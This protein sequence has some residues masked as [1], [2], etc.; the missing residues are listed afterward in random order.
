MIILLLILL[1]IIVL[2]LITLYFTRLVVYPKVLSHAY[3]KE[4]E[5]RSKAFDEAYLNSFERKVVHIPSIFGY[6]LSGEVIL[7]NDPSAPF[8]LICHG[9]TSNYE[10]S[11]NMLNYF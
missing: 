2:M 8:V 5:L 9:I 10:G 4:K 11:K 6:A 7:Q 1:T 3:V